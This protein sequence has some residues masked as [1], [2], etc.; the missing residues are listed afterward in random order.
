MTAVAAWRT[1]HT[2]S[3]PSTINKQRQPNKKV[4]FLDRAFAYGRVPGRADRRDAGG[5]SDR[6][7]LAARAVDRA[8]RP[9]LPPGLARPV[10]LVNTVLAADGAVDP[11]ILAINAASAALLRSGLP[12]GG[13]VAA[14]KVGLVDGELVVNPPPARAALSDLSLTY[15]GASGRR[16]T[17]VEAA[18]EQ[19]P[20]ARVAEALRFAADA[21]EA[22]LAPQLELAKRAASVV[23]APPPLG[24]VPLAPV[25]PR[26]RAAVEALALDR[27]R[28]LF[29][30]AAADD[31][32]GKAARGAALAALQADVLDGLRL[33][34][35]LP[36][37]GAPG[38]PPPGT[39]P[40]AVFAEADALRALDALLSRAMRAALVS[41]AGRR[42]DGRALDELR[43]ISAVV[44]VLPRGVHGSALFERGETQCLAAATVAPEREAV[45]VDGGPA[46]HGVAS[47]PPLPVPLPANGS[48]GG[49]ASGAAEGG[50]E[51]G[52]RAAAAAAAAAATGAGPGA[53]KRLLLHYSF[54]PYCTGE[55]G[56]LGGRTGRRE[57][58][59]GA[60][61][62][63]ALA[64]LMPP[65]EAFPFW[66]RVSAETLASSGSSSMA[67]VCAGALALRAAGVPTPALAA[68]VSVGLAVER[69]P[70]LDLP[71]TSAPPTGG[72]YSP[73]G[74]CGADW[75]G[76]RALL[77]DIEG[78]EDHLGDMDFKVAGTR[79]GVTA[80]HLDTK[81]PGLPVEV[82]ADALA[83]A[84]AARAEILDALEAALAAHDARLPEG[85]R[86]RCGGVAIDRE[87]VP[88]LIGLQVGVLVLFVVAGVEL[89]KR[90]ENKAAASLSVC[91]YCV[92]T[93]NTANTNTNKRN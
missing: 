65:H 14:V 37:L 75:Y 40:G 74:A 22:L 36:D 48:A 58:G 31:N 93:D 25:A 9:L 6:E 89:G 30:A 66:A 80:L 54:P 81:L 21:A 92:P 71:T 68:G 8:L 28:A 60:L 41:G 7:V 20:E 87:L 57:V 44:G 49:A 62:E 82:L 76:R 42:L 86:P 18:A 2:I 70:Q 17:M 32:G 38:A 34:G 1:I 24:V 53:P 56:K 51:A 64:P 39:V 50:S 61:A 84:A 69:A 73:G 23:P 35:L 90:G 67:A 4:D 78:A 79:A 5:A 16:A 83:P 46:L 15:A 26:L 11:E 12:W 27:C 10:Q 55:A 33:Q 43:P 52:A 29:S 72:V 85:A 63:K 59:H 19:V 45:A 77:T 3:S 47:S 91:M 13:P 88:R